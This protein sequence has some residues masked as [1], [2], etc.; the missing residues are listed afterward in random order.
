MTGSEDRAEDSPIERVRSVWKFRELTTPIT[1]RKISLHM[2]GTLYISCMR[3]AMLCGSET[4][5]LKDNDVK[6]LQCTKM[7]MMCNVTV[8]YG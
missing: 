1:K 2:K 6:R 8:I 5:P 4:W 7:S 3:S